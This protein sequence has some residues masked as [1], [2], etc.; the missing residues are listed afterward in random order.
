MSLNTLRSFP[1][2]GCYRPSVDQ[3]LLKA[4]FPINFYDYLHSFALVSY[5]YFLV[6]QRPQ[7]GYM[8]VCGQQLAISGKATS[9]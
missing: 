1:S 4:F 6:R 7:L 5:I 2:E 9:L 3:H 8:S